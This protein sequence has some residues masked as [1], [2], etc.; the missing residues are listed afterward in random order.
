MAPRNAPF[1]VEEIEQLALINRLSTHHDPLAS[2]K[3]LTET[4][5]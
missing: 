1:E 3:S 4:E 5:S 2:L